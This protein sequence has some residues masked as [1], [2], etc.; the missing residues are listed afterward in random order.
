MFS[1]PLHDSNFI[2]QAKNNKQAKRGQTQVSKVATS[3]SIESVQIQAN[4][5]ARIN[6]GTVKAEPKPEE[7]STSL[8][9]SVTIQLSS[10]KEC[11]IDDQRPLQSQICTKKGLLFVSSHNRKKPF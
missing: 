11:G 9:T 1:S 6:K 8:D 5:K 10:M 3:V 2:F 4:S 7:L